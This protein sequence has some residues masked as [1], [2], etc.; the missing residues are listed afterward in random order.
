MRSVGYVTSWKVELDDSIEIQSPP[1]VQGHQAPPFV[2]GA[3]TPGRA[4]SVDST[5]ALSGKRTHG[6]VPRVPSLA[7]A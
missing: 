7:S 5:S 1:L 6:E 2:R 4:G 3:L